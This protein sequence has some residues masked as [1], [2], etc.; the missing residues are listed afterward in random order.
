MSD[1]TLLLAS[2]W[3]YPVKSMMG[4]ELNTA[5][6][7][8]NG[9]L[10]DR[11]YALLDTETNKIV[12]A[13]NPKKWPEIFY[14][15]A[16][17]QH[18]PELNQ[19]IPEVT[20]TLPNGNTLNSAQSD[21]QALLTA[22]LKRDVTLIKHAPIKAALEQ[23]WPEYEGQPLEISDEVISADAGEGSFFDYSSLHIL[24]TASLTALQTRYPAGR[25]ESRRF[26]PNLIIA[27]QP[28]QTGFVENN[29]VGKTLRIGEVRLLITD[30]CPRC[31]MPTLAQSDLAKDNKILK[32]IAENTVHVP[33]ANKS[34]PSVGV[35]AKVLQA[36][37]IKRSDVVIIE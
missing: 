25:M 24:T 32:V 10:G 16:R 8:D 19:A 21:A 29:W 6:I 27:T 3:R 1:T 18:A 31:V 26:R 11:S 30:P 2:L 37:V 33:F 36:G 14:F 34:L 13:K 22:A 9:I 20:I 12:S 28:E 17:Y 15:H 23:Y 5:V 4:E 7:T 35:Y